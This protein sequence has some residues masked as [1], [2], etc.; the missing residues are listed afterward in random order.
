[1]KL[2]VL[3]TT[4]A[5]LSLCASAC[6]TSPDDGSCVGERKLATNKLAVNKLATNKLATNKLATNGL[7]TVELL[8]G[9]LRT[10][11]IADTVP[12]EAL[13]DEF[14]QDVLEYM[15]GCALAPEQ[16]VEVDV[17][18]EHRVYRGALGLAPAWGAEAGACDGA[19]QGWVSACLIA[20]TNAEGVSRPISLLGDHPGLV[21]SADESRDFD[22]EEATYFGDLF[23]PDKTMYACVPA[24]ADAP[25]RTCG[26]DAAGCAIAIVGACE[27]VCDAAGCRG[28]DGVVYGEHITVNLPED[29]SSCG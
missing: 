3:P 15:V 4:L 26:D 6:V 22:I 5:I 10:A 23:G 2:A 13:A 19:C 12:A 1:M 14:V 20:R 27:D 28:A 7:L 9:P 21:P 8:E 25:V 11:A 29:A 17:A 24:G 18:G 16:S